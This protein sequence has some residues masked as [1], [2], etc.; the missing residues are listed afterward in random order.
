MRFAMQTYED[1]HWVTVADIST[2]TT[3]LRRELAR[4]TSDVI[5]VWDR[6]RMSTVCVS[7]GA[8]LA[9]SDQLLNSF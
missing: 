9:L 7:F 5:R 6:V 3:S 4:E 1:G 8:Y 2:P